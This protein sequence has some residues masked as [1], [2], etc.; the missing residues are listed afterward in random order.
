VVG[1]RFCGTILVPAFD[2]I[3]NDR[4]LIQNQLLESR[5]P[6][7]MAVKLHEP[8]EHGIGDCGEDRIAADGSDLPMETAI[9]FQK[10]FGLGARTSLLLDP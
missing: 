5:C 7:G 2:E 10:K 8:A 4:V 6:N 3:G 9:G 1:H